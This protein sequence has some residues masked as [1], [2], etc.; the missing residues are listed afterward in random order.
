MDDFNGQIRSLKVYGE[1]F[2]DFFNKQTQKV[3]SRILWTIRLV[4]DIQFVPKT[5]LKYLESTDGLYEVRVSSGNN[6]FRIFCFF[7]EG[8]LVILLN[9]F[10]KKT[11]KTPK[12]EIE[13]AEKLKI[14]YYE[15]K[16]K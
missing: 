6:I 8:Q 9:G 15:D 5:Y 16:Q 13:R 11:Q 4:R 2:W 14:K 1:Y 10:Q 7:D 12:Q 3:Q